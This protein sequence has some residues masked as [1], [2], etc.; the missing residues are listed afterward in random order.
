MLWPAEAENSRSGRLW[1]SLALS[2]SPRLW[3]FL[4]FSGPLWASASKPAS[5]SQPAPASQEETP[6]SQED[7][8]ASQDET[9]ANQ[10]ETSARRE[11]TPASSENLK[12]Y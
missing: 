2:L 4:G 9:P 5:S 1:S 8:P 10:E 11:E 3:A 12:I 6:A 7:T